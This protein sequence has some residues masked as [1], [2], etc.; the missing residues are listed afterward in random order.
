MLLPLVRQTP[1]DSLCQASFLPLLLSFDAALRP[2]DSQ[3]APT[4]R[5]VR[6]PAGRSRRASDAPGPKDCSTY[7]TGLHGTV[8]RLE[9]NVSQIQQIRS[10]HSTCCRSLQSNEEEDAVRTQSL[11]LPSR[12][13]PLR[14]VADC[15]TLY[16][17]CFAVVNVDFCSV[18]MPPNG[19][20]LYRVSVVASTTLY[21]RYRS[22]GR[23][24]G[25]SSTLR[26]AR[27]CR[28]PL[29]RRAPC[30]TANDGRLLLQQCVLDVRMVHTST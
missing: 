1:L 19:P 23:C 11:M 27:R 16:L 13:S 3:C 7:A 14:P 9:S 5:L 8:S 15:N 4:L 20:T 10:L 12:I 29:P 24:F 21:R 22:F 30:A 2:K 25:R 6:T 18:V 28:A 26:V 17:S